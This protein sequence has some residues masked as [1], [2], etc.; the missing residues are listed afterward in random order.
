M[1]LLRSLCILALLAMVTSCATTSQPSGTPP[2]LAKLAALKIDQG[3]YYKIAN[4]RVLT[5]SDILGLL[6]KNVPS[7]VIL[8]YI[9]ST[10]APYTLTNS[11]ITTLNNA[12]ASADLLN[13]LGKSIGFFEA[14]ERSQ[15]GGAGKWRNDP[16]FTDPYF[17]GDGP[18]GPGFPGEW[19]DPMWVG[20]VF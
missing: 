10:H 17:M 3:T 7:P 11:Q 5:Y 16:Y 13:Y 6:Q 19:Y 18:F 20:E 14:T 9:Q 4:H 2:V 8:T 1:V 15:T 12:G